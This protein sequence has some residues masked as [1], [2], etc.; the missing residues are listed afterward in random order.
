M[1]MRRISWA[2]R[3]RWHAANPHGECPNC[4]AAI[5]LYEGHRVC[6]RCHWSLE[7][8]MVEQLLKR[9]CECSQCQA[10]VVRDALADS[11]DPKPEAH[12]AA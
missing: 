6:F 1:A 8:G 11:P 7:P 4:H 9:P 2:E 12:D 10:A 3:R 5:Q